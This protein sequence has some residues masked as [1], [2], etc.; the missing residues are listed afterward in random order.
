MIVLLD[1]GIL[2]ALCAPEPDHEIHNWFV[3]ALQRGRQL[4]LPEI[5][6]YELRRE[7]KRAGLQRSL[8]RLEDLAG[9]I[10]YL[11]LT[12]EAMRAAA[13]FWAEVRNAHAPTA[14]D[15]A[16]DG[17]CIL[18]AQ[19]KACGRASNRPVVVATT[20]V[21]HLTLMVDAR[22]WREIA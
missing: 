21:K 16:L 5:C 22:P 12:T 8:A 10:S 11:P 20:N 18:A 4:T 6:D 19:A 13:D 1:T 3:G 14:S 17:D 7:L 2:G 9:T 15:D